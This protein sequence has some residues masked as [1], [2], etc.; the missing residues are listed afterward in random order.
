MR[1]FHLMRVLRLGWPITWWRKV[2]GAVY[3][4]LVDLPR[5]LRVEDDTSAALR[6]RNS[7]V[8]LQ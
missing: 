6:L 3:L 7:S 2:F 8:E 5:R 1:G 4:Y